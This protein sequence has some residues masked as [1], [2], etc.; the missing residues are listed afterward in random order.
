MQLLL[1][2][3][4]LL[5]PKAVVVFVESKS[6]VLVRAGIGLLVPLPPFPSSSFSVLFFSPSEAWSLD[7]AQWPPQSQMVQLLEF[8]KY[9][10][11]VSCCSSVLEARRRKGD[12][13]APAA[14]PSL[15]HSRALCLL[16]HYR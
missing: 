9:L 13:H 3:L 4:S 8:A 6:A 5:L 16:M 14:V 1:G 12:R 11:K 7:L 15:Q 2:Q 10:R